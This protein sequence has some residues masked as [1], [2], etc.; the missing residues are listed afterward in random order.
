MIPYYEMKPQQTAWAIITS[1]ENKLVVT[2]CVIVDAKRNAYDDVII[3]H[4]TG[5]MERYQR[6]SINSLFHTKELA[7]KE[8]MRIH[9]ET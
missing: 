9:G 3:H 2:M 6:I 8:L 1:P 7:D 5:H 4:F